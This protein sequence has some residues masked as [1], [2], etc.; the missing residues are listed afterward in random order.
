MRM[1]NFDRD[2]DVMISGSVFVV[3]YVDQRVLVL[4]NLITE[5]FLYLD[6]DFPRAEPE[7][8]IKQ[9]PREVNIMKRL[10]HKY[11]VECAKERDK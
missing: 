6:T 3:Y 4:F 8:W 7:S 11:C 2:I 5:Y 9:T 10:Y 1:M